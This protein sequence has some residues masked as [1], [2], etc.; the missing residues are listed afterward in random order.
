MDIS[1][2]IYHHIGKPASLESIKDNKDVKY[3]PLFD[4]YSLNMKNDLS[5]PIEWYAFGNKSSLD[6]RIQTEPHFAFKV[7]GIVA[8][9]N[10]QEI[11]MPL[12]EAFRRLLLAMIQLNG[13]LIEVI[14]TSLPEEKIW[15]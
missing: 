2:M 10:G 8:V 5:L 14:E 7:N 6:S 13:V 9:L 4:M 3:S 1:K 12:Y 15:I 11:V